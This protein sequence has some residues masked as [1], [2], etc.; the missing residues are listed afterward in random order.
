[1]AYAKYKNVDTRI[2]RIFNTYGPK[3]RKND[4]RAIPNFIN[5]IMNNKNITV[6][7]DGNQTRSFCYVEDTILGIY[8]ALNSNY[9]LPINIG[10]SNELTIN[11]LID[12][13]K[14]LIPSK[15]KKKYFQLPE[16]DPKIRKPDISL[17][18]KI[19]DWE[20]KTNIEEGLKQT[21]NYFYNYK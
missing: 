16:N 12:L 19:L 17:A 13:L 21:I 9:S 15:S 4:G 8:M 2:V 3:M 5:Q 18:K 1:M 14:K 11:E 7:G 20:P 10:N 6:Y